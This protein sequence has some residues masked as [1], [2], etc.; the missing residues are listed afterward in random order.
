MRS[1]V[2]LT[3]TLAAACAHAPPPVSSLD[4]E[5][6]RIASAFFGLDDA[7]PEAARRLCRDAPGADGMPITFSR[8]VVGDLDPGAF[9]VTTRSGARLHPR[10][11]TTRPAN[12]DAEGHTVLLLGQLGGEPADPPVEVEV[13]GALALAG[14]DGHGLRAP[15]IALAAGPTLALAIATPPGAIASDCPA[16][17]AQIVTAIWTGGVNLAPGVDDDRHRRGYRVQTDTGEVAPRALGDL[18]DR[19]NYEH[20]CLAT[21]APVRRVAFAAGLLVDPRGDRN[22]ATAIAVSAAR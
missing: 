5:P 13:T 16:G 19:D 2:A 6:P 17:T 18:G 14:A 4:A 1:R 20:L 15:V 9:T 8:R 12:G 7:I 10:C 21:A 22:P 11:A 3:L